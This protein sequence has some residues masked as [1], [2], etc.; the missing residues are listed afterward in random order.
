[1]ELRITKDR[2]LEPL[3]YIIRR[4]SEYDT[5]PEI[6]VLEAS[7]AGRDGGYIFGTRFKDRIF[8]LN[9]ISEQKFCPETIDR[10]W[11]RVTEILN[12][13]NGFMKLYRDDDEGVFGEVLVIKNYQFRR[14]PDYVEFTVS[15]LLKDGFYK[16]IAFNEITS[17]DNGMVFVD[18]T[19]EVPF[20]LEERKSDRSVYKAH[21]LELNG[22][23]LDIKSTG[24]I[25]YDS[26]RGI[27]TSD[28][29]N[30]IDNLE[31]DFLKLERG[32]NEVKV[33]DDWVL[34]FRDWYSF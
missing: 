9:L 23:V 2:R 21:T 22:K 19:V 20:Y 27:V 29:L 14:N 31:G 17:M 13:R 15:L 8:N 4:D 1:M 32:Y 18:S 16:S 33:H 7:V 11:R 5:L 28:G 6:E 30:A 10:E 3:G 12:P 26:Y 24:K 34:R 25:I